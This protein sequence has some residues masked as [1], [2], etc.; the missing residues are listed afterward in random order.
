[1]DD[2]AD[3]L[4]NSSVGHLLAGGMS[5]IPTMKLRLSSPGELIDLNGLDDLQGISRDGNTLTISAMTR[6]AEV[7]ASA[8]VASS[9]PA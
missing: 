9:V 8:E 7:A 6:H 4:R 5:L 2:A 1:M 3:S